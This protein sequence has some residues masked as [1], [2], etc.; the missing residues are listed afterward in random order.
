ML[1]LHSAPRQTGAQAPGM[2][3]LGQERAFARV[4]FA[5]E[6]DMAWVICTHF[7]AVGRTG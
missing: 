3:A 5:P 1:N 2:S 4:R 6:A 7:D